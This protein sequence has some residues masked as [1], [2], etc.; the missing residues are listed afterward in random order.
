[1]ATAVLESL[2]SDPE[3]S[4]PA[5]PAK[6]AAAAKSE[7]PRRRALIVLPVLVALA[8]G[9]AGIAYVNGRGKETTDELAIRQWLEEK[10][11]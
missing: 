1:M 7:K 4:L 10:T 2:T 3:A 9:S 11:P 6:P 5:T 8:A